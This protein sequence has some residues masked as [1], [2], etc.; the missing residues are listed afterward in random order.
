MIVFNG[1]LV[2]ASANTI[3]WATWD[4]T[5]QDYSNA[6]IVDGKD[7]NNANAVG[8]GGG[9]ALADRT[10]TQNGTIDGNGTYRTLDGATEWFDGTTGFRDFLQ[11][12]SVYGIIFKLENWSSTSLATLIRWTGLD[13][14]LIRRQETTKNLEVRAQNAAVGITADVPVD[15]AVLYVYFGCNGA[16]ARMGFT[17]TTRPTKWSDFAATKRVSK[18]SAITLTAMNEAD[19]EIFR[20]AS[21]SSRYVAVLFHYAVFAKE[22]ALI[23]FNS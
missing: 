8:L 11:G 14:I 2:S 18:G 3:N 5:E 19:P 7:A 1:S 16:D 23:D 15:N 9:L 21:N 22:T 17:E 20:D 10:W 4:E 12:Q 13:N 6:F